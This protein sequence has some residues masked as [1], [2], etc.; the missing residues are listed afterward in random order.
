MRHASC[1]TINRLDTRPGRRERHSV[2]PG[3]REWLAIGA[4]D[5]VCVG[6]EVVH[7]DSTGRICAW[8]GG[9]GFGSAW[10]A[11]TADLAGGLLVSF[12]AAA[13]VVVVVLPCRCR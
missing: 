11:A 8:E 12:G 7:A 13:F 1:G 4:T 9:D 3:V 2:D 10:V 6:G 5:M